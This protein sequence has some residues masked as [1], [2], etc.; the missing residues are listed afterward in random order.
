MTDKIY[1][2]MFT[3]YEYSLLANNHMIKM[4]CKKQLGSNKKKGDEIE[5]SMTL[6]EL[7][8]L[9]GHVAAEANHARPKRA[10]VELGEI[11]DCL[12]SLEFDIKRAAKKRE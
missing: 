5:L 7:T 12:E 4:V 6:A 8:D 1:P 9:I 10:A 2:V 3:E 11:C